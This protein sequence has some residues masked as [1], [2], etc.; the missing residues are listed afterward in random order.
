MLKVLGFAVATAI[1]APAAAWSQAVPQAPASSAAAQQGGSADVG[2]QGATTTQAPPSASVT[3]G[4][5]IV[6]A[7]QRG[8]NLQKAAVPVDVVKG[9]DLVASGVT[10]V[11]YIN[12]LVP[13]LTIEG[14]GSGNIIFIRGVGNFALQTS[15]D[16]AVAFNYDGIYIGRPISTA[17]TF[18]DLQ[19]IE[20]LKGPQGTLYGRNATGGAINVIPEQP[21]LNR[22]TGYASTSFGNYGTSDTEG[23]VNLPVGDNAAFRV[24]GAYV[25]HDGYLADGTSSEDAGGVRVQFKD[26]LTPDVTLRLSGDYAHQGGTGQGESY[27][28]KYTPNPA[29][30]QNIVTPSNIPLSQGEF[31]PEGQAFL[32]TVTA[33]TAGR[34]FVPFTNRPFEDNS[35]YGL[36]LQLDWTTP[37]GVV[38]ILP[39]W[40]HTDKDNLAVPGFI[41]A[42][43][44]S[45]N[46]Y[47]V[48]TRLVGSYNHVLDYNAGIYFYDETINDQ[49]SANVESLSTF[50]QAHYRTDSYAAYGRLTWHVTDKLRL[51]GGVRYTDDLKD[52]H[53]ASQT[54]V[55][56]C[57]LPTGCPAAPLLPYTATL[58]E[59][60]FVP[61]ASGGV[62]V[63]GAGTIVSRSDT[64][65]RSALSV[66]K[67]TYRFGVEYD[68]APRSLGY[69]TVEK[70][71]RSGGFNTAAGF[72]TYAPETITAYTVGLKNRFFDNRLQLNL[73][74]FDWEYHDQQLTTLGADSSGRPVAFTRNIGQSR[75]RGGEA[76]LKYAVT[77]QTIFT[78]DVQYLDAYYRSFKY[79]SPVAGGVPLTGCR[80]ALDTAT[81]TFYDV[82]CT[83]R[84]SF[85]TPHWTLN[86]AL[87]HTIPIGGYDLVLS[88]N[89]QYRGGRYTSFEYLAAEHVGPTTQTDLQAAVSPSDGKW[90]VALYI[91]NLEDDRF[92][93][94]ANPGVQANILVTDSAQPRL[95]GARLSAKF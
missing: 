57:R 40:R 53:T 71:Y 59:Q 89:T 41:L 9:S 69:A 65:A 47:S 78:A 66:Q 11:D 55:L 34:T 25:R 76:E 22:F 20:V 4:E 29:T 82:D 91:H 31:S 79:Q 50:T 24:S 35:V 7:Q 72:L 14:T 17:T 70:G 48:E 12:K 46:Q 42:D 15:S 43:L 62:S 58:A 88:A 13:A 3:L 90:T 54:L 74:G 87:Q 36:H 45:D 75:I 85:N 81:P 94:Y 44:Q 28:L 16:P 80:V 5:V 19:R 92:Q 73:E 26:A 27:L 83:G 84:P 10:S 93:V 63:S 51:S 2:P 60:P 6:T 38:T 52:F 8:E 77:P 39:A 56:V 67:P 32:Q 21:I 95:Y 61:A 30:L 1:A 86:G 18:Y 68:L 23:A 37:I 64:A 49:Q 33:G